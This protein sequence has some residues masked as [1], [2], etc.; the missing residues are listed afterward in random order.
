MSFFYTSKE[1]LL[2]FI[3]FISEFCLLLN[4]C[5]VLYE[6]CIENIIE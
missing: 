4:D 2:D 1:F 3:Q 5:F 6:I